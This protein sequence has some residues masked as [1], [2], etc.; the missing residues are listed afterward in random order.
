MQGIEKVKVDRPARKGDLIAYQVHRSYVGQ[1]YETVRWSVWRL[2]V[3]ESAS[4]AGMVRKVRQS[5]YDTVLTVIGPNG[6]TVPGIGRWA[7]APRAT[8]DMVALM[9]DEELWG[10]DLENLAEV[11]AALQQYKVHAAS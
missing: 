3:V 11:R 8:V 1:N 5:G 7:V 10:Q 2:G 6:Y 9:A 4:R